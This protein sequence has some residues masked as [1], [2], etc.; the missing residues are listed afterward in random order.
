MREY[1]L[2]MLIGAVIF[3]AAAAWVSASVLKPFG[4][5]IEKKAERMAEKVLPDTP[6]PA[7]DYV[8]AY[9]RACVADWREFKFKGLKLEAREIVRPR[10]ENAYVSL[11]LVREAEAREGRRR[12]AKT[13]DLEAM[14]RGLGRELAP[15]MELAEAIR[16]SARLAILGA[17]GVGKSTLLQWA[18]LACARVRLNDP[19]EPPKPE[20]RA[21]AEALGQPLIPVFVTLRDFNYWCREQKQ[22]RSPDSLLAFL[23]ADFDAR[24]ASAALPPAFFREALERGCLLLLDGV[25]EL[26]AD[27]RDRVGEA[28]EGLLRDFAQPANRFLL[29]SRPTGYFSAG[30]V[31]GFAHCE[32]QRLT[33]E[34]RDALI[35]DWSAAIYPADEAPGKADRLSRRID[36]QAQL[37]ELASTPLMV[38]I[39]ALVQQELTELP[40]QRAE[41]YEEA[42]KI[43]LTETYK[44]GEAVKML[45][46][47]GGLS[48]EARRN[49]L[50]RIAW[51]LHNRPER[52]H[53]LRRD[54]LA[55]LVR[56]EFRSEAESKEAAAVF[57]EKVAERGGLLDVQNNEYGFF[58]HNMF[59]EFLAGRHLAERLESEWPKHLAAHL[60][61]NLWEETLRLAAGYLAINNE[62]KANR[63]IRLLAVEIGSTDPERAQA[64][65]L[66]GFAASDLAAKSVFIETRRAVQD[67]ALPLLTANP[68]VVQEARARRRLGLALAALG[69]PRF[70]P[71]PLSPTGRGAGGEGLIP[72]LVT[73]PAGVFRMGTSDAEAE[74]LKAQNAESWGDEKHQH[75]VFVSQFQMG[76]YPVTNAEFRAFVDAKG[77]ENKDYWSDDGWRWRQGELKPDL[78]IYSEEFRKRLEEWLEGRPVGKRNQ[79]FFWDDPQW[80]ADNLPVVGVTWYEAE[81]YCRWLSALTGQNFRLPT[82]A[83][84]EKAARASSLPLSGGGAGGGGRLWPWGDTWDAERCN[85]EESKLGAT[86]PVGM[87]PHGAAVWPDGPVEDLI[88]N[89]WE[90]CAD[91]YDGGLYQTRASREQAERDPKGPAQGSARVVRGGSF[92]APRWSCRSAYRLRLVPVHFLGSIGFRVVR[93]P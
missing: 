91:W 7:P 78:S 92:F 89:V 48:P 93:S 64:L 24:H 84:W 41:L 69:D 77:Y 11:R 86:T 67:R 32:V 81:A 49:R 57:I 16:H 50:A 14:A 34:Q 20:Q 44:E 82:E 8:T 59:R 42:V 90:W 79:P 31:T 25:D 66:A 70:T 15:P 26:E 56:D 55:E 53:A 9:L 83:E 4:S 46:G 18:G 88:G 23:A 13:A 35:R 38:T 80:N 6:P 72:A 39:L 63:F 19:A 73:I 12:G 71:A 62:E 10:L 45:K 30:Q 37:R 36:A 5:R 51:E 21:F 60:A 54:E 52:R 40:Q 22:P 68:P 61:D 3:F 58:T 43:L 2:L 47:W 65:T 28:I 27:D 76:R 75:T 17:A 33:P 87:Y 29:A 85:S 74:Q 1:G